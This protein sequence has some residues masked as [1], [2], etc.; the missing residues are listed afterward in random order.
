MAADMI[1]QDQRKRA[2][3]AL[4]R[5]F[6]VA[7]AE[8]QQQ[9]RNKRRR[10]EEDALVKNR[11]PPVSSAA[12][13]VSAS[14]TPLLGTSSKKDPKADGL[15]YMQI[16]HPVSEKLVASV[17]ISN[18]GKSVVN[19]ILHELLKSGDSASKYI[20]GSKNMKM[21]NWILLDNF[22]REHG[23]SASRLRAFQNH[24]KRSKR[25]MSM[26]QLK[27]CR[28]FELPEEYRKFDVFLPMHQMWKSYVTQLLKNTGRNQI[29]QCLLGADLHG[30]ILRVVECKV[31][32][33]VGVMGIM[34]R[35]T[36]ETFGIIT[37]ENKFKVVPKKSSVFVLQ[38]DCWKITLQGDKFASR[39]P[40]P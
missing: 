24:S 28:A 6:A 9:V 14:A 12:T 3:E 5:R 18:Q 30:A 7:K 31:D 32:A 21:D 11:N 34:I 20:Q 22:V 1:I 13:A 15:I 19:N 16:C 17:S 25:H 35:Q 4:E 29:A 8:A 39:K 33:L 27:K 23:S 2:M 26:K 10:N 40:D 37:Q 38:A 36:A